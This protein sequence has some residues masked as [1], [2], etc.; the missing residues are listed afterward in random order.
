MTSSSSAS[1]SDG[2]SG[3]SPADRTAAAFRAAVES[4]D[5]AAGV[6][7]LAEDVVFSSPIVH[8]TYT[9]RDQVAPVLFAVG[10][11][12]E[13]FRYTAEFSSADG[14]VLRF[15]ARVDDRDIDGVDILTV[16]PDG[17]IVEFAVMVR[18]YSAATA[19]RT[20]MAALLT[21]PS[22]S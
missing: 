12:F 15:S 10:T 22:G 6:A 5:M 4:D 2:G 1:S 19:L 3:A 9:G 17:Q 8:R 20:R 14:H 13:D 7:L 21:G 16:A 11:V 18:P